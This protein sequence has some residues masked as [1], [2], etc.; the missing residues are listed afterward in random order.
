[1][2]AGTLVRA[3]ALPQP[4]TRDITVWKVWSFGAMHDLTG[5]YGVGGNP[6]ERRSL[7]WQGDEATVD[8]PPLSL[9][10]LAGAGHL[11]ASFRPQFDDGPWLN[12]A[13][14]LPGVLAEVLLVCVLLTWG[15]RQFGEAA[16]NWSALAFW[17]NPAVLMDGPLLG[18]LDA[19]MAV[20]ATIAIA[21]ALAGEVWIAGAL[22]AI[23]VL[24]KAQAV[25]VLPVVAATIGWHPVQD[26]LRRSAEAV[27]GASLVG[28]LVIGPYV[29]RGAWSNL[30]QA[31]GRLAT[32][33]MLSANAA[34]VWWIF[35][36][37]LRVEDVWREWGGW[38]ALTQE[39]RILAISRAV[40]LGYPNARLIGLAIVALAIG[41]AVWR[42]RRA[43]TPA[44]AFAFAGWCAY[45]YALCAAQV[46]ENHL[47]LAVP[48]LAVA[49]GADRRFRG[50]FWATS[51]VV[52]LNLLL[53]Y[54]LG[55]G[56]PWIVDRRWTGIDASVWLSALSVLVFVVATRRLSAASRNH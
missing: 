40:A 13:V 2:V 18:Y 54:G 11:Y 28:A 15:P 30:I 24:T 41:W 5:A 35:T 16:A 20:P 12:A 32:H 3:L 52:C 55:R 8:Y 25:F 36:W 53:F 49:A 50:F 31:V 42:L 47:Y 4:G 34:N 21:A 14:K 33:D 45:A 51:A 10:E 37:I 27:L 43:P 22:A 44:L 46:H 29:I 39:V 23:A 38:R 48:F 26:R 56:L 6:P 7:R 1:L 17:L 9:V 19:Q